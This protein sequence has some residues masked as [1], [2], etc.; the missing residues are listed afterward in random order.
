MSN[1]GY[2]FEDYAIPEDLQK[3]QEQIT[4]NKVYMEL[5]KIQRR[6]DDLYPPSLREYSAKMQSYL[7]EYAEM[8]A[9]LQEEIA[10][11][12]PIFDELKRYD[13][14]YDNAF[15]SIAQNQAAMELMADIDSYAIWD[16]FSSFKESEK[17]SQEINIDT[18]SALYAE[19]KITDEDIVEEVGEMVSKKD[20]SFSD[21][22]DNF[23]KSKWFLAI[24]VVF[25]ILTFLASPAIDRA[26][27]DI[28]EKMRANEFWK[29]SGVL[30]QIDKFFGIKS[31]AVSE[32]EAKDTV[33][34]EN[35]GNISKKKRESLLQKIQ[36]IRDYISAAPQDENTGNLLAYLSELEKDVNGKKYGLVFEEHREEIDEVLD[37]HTPVLTEEKELFIDNGGH[38]NF[39]IEGDNLAAL[40]LLEKT[41]RGKIDLIYIDPPYN[42]GN[43][44]FTYNDKNIVE[45]DEYRHSKWISFISERLRIAKKLISTDGVIVISI[46]HQEVN[47]LML[48][49]QEMFSDKNITCI[50]VQTSGGKPNSGFNY[51][52]EYVVFIAPFDFEPAASETARNE[53]SSPYHGMNL[54][55]FDQVQRP[56]QAYPI[57]VSNDGVLVGCGKTLTER[58][59]CGE[60]VG[61]LRDFIY[62]YSEAPEGTVAIWPVTKK[63]TP[64]VWR[65]IPS[66]LVNDWQKG[67][68][69]IVP[70]NQ[71]K[72]NNVFAIQYLSDG[73]I[74]KIK[75][76]E[77][78]TFR[79]SED[80]R[81]PTL[82]VENYR[83]AGATIQTIWTD[84]AYYTSNGGKEIEQIL[85]SKK[86]FSYPKPL[87]L[88]KEIV[89]RTTQ[90]CSIVLDFFAGSGTTGHAVMKLNAEDGG[91]RRFI[92]CTNNENNICRGVTY[93]RIKR[94]IDKE[95]YAASLKYYRVDYVPIDERMYYEYADELLKHIR[96]LVELENGVNFIGNAEIGIVLTEEEL[97]AFVSNADA[98]SK[99]KKLYIGHDLLPT[100]DQEKALAE[101]GI[102]IS[103]IPDYYYRDLQER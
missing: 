31:G 89:Q 58:V 6:I 64:C 46:G 70:Q 13:D 33:S 32:Q 14:F 17:I 7:N 85:G 38:M 87:E 67:Y 103:I 8:V 59:K 90:E 88:I 72:T 61:E 28:L 39:L 91:S 55:T 71:G 92:L 45:S 41:H 97:E 12:S 5:E 18:A 9:K 20:F 50:T 37:T 26:K 57:Y 21:T 94:V 101:H 25:V 75:N 77:L 4:N 10:L 95:S 99:C 81:I 24:R 100:Q 42:T 66:R 44:D 19:G 15:A 54:A 69:K 48:I 11:F 35:V 63:G 62:D 83:T 40:K 51:T 98:F 76:G 34:E 78:T 47:N 68:I 3:L 84:K 56:G 36:A 102:E 49:C 93:E 43:M 96:E 22:W 1:N 29:E 65:L 73:I 79:F 60:Y 16:I 53:Y 2:F 52:H 82:E 80:S 30:E 23:K 27:D 86:A 74:Q